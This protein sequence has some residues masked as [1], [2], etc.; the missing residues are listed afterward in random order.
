[1]R[2]YFVTATGT[3]V[4]KTYVTAGILRAAA[5]FSAIKPLLSGY[6][7]ATAAA[8]DSAILLAAMRKRVTHKNI[9]AITPWRFV[10]P[11]SPDAAAAR[12]FRHVDF[13]SLLTFCHAAM[14]AAPGHL[15]IE[16]VGG[17]AVPLNTKRLVIDWIFSLRIPAILVA[18]T[19][20][21]TIS[22]TIT[23]ANLLAARGIPIAAIVLS[24]DAAPALSSAETATI[25]ARFLPHPIHIVPRDFNDLSF[26]G[27]ADRL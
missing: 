1:M 7:Q 14:D 10:A 26:Q 21:G 16:G 4:G 20:L 27:L 23:A 18:G 12:E 19:Y 25:L 13:E 24:E 11:L 5:N 17:V 9:A 6:T 3:G 8:S 15:L 22:H 2:S